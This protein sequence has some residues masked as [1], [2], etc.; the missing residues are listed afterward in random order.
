MK[1]FSFNARHHWVL[2][3]PDTLGV[4]SNIALILLNE[5]NKFQ[6]AL[7]MFNSTLR[8]KELCFGVTN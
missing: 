7:D 5:P 1:I 8:G 4:T 6:E 3:P 2:S